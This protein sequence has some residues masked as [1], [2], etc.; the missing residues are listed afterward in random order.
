[1]GKLSR[2]KGNRYECEIVR[3]LQDE[4]IA[5]E[6]V[7]LSGAAGG[8]FAG[9][10]SVPFLRRDHRFECKIK[11]QGFSR[12][13]G[14]LKEHTGLFLRADRQPTLVVLRMTDFCALVQEAEQ[15]RSQRETS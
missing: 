11:A 10:I 12:L 6:R 5:A 15:R 1:M 2:N 4:G 14:W 9:D 3:I 8:R 13:Y 7:P